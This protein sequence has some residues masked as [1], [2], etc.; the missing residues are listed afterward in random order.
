MK[1]KKSSTSQPKPSPPS[2]RSPHLPRPAPAWNRRWSWYFS[3]MDTGGPFSF[4]WKKM[5]SKQLQMILDRLKEFERHNLDGL[6]KAN[7]HPI[8]PEDLAKDAQTRLKT[9]KRDDIEALWS[10]RINSKA[11]V[12]AMQHDDVFA[13]LWWDP[14]HKVYPSE[15][16][17]T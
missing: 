3:D 16:K 12:W 6:K 13:L 7:C 8:P 10:F 17:H 11:R 5:D 2:K 15:K 1:R 14:E 9:L 4:S